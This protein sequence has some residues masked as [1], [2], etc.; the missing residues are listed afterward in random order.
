MFTLRSDEWDTHI[1]YI[2][3]FKIKQSKTKNKY[4]YVIE[5]IH[6]RI[7]FNYSDGTLKIFYCGRRMR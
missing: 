1:T 2:N 6:I 4:E 7:G 5:T 3:S